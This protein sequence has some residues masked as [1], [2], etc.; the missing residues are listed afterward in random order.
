[1]TPRLL[2]VI[3][4]GQEAGALAGM[5]VLAAIARG[6]K[7]VV[8]LA[9]LRRLPRA[10]MDGQDRVV[11][12]ADQEMARIA[13]A[14]ESTLAAAMRQY[15]DVPVEYVVRFGRPGRELRV[16]A[17]LFAP[18]LIAFFTSPS[19]AARS[20]LHVWWLRRR[21]TRRTDTRVLL[22]QTRRPTDARPRRR[23]RATLRWRDGLA[24]RESP[25]G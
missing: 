4:E 16:E 13:T 18:A 14:A 9:Y 2:A 15:D 1:M 17:D 6:E 7:A 25:W 10:R 23:P 8:R 3:I 24:A 22:L 11:A 21:L 20:R 12:D 5:A 19:A